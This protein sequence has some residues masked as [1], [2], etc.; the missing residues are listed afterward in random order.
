MVAAGVVFTLIVTSSK[1]EVTP[2]VIVALYVVVVVGETDIVY[3]EDVE[4][5]TTPPAVRLVIVMVLFFW[6]DT[7]TLSS[8]QLSVEALVPAG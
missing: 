1:Q 4:L 6:A 8:P 3:G 7:T 5:P 2:S